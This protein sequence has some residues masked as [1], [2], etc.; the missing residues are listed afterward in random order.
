MT[1]TVLDANS[2]PQT[3]QTLPAPG[4]AAAVASSPIVLSTEDLA[5]IQYRNSPTIV[6]ATITR[7]SDTNAYT[8]GDAFAN[9][10]SA[11]TAGGF[12]LSSAVR[13]S[14]KSAW[15]EDITITSS[16]PTATALQGELL[17][18]NQAFTAINDNAA[19]T[20]SPADM[21]N[22]IV[23]IP[24]A[25]YVRGASASTVFMPIRKLVRPTGTADLRFGVCV[26]N[27]YVP[28]IGEALT[29]SATLTPED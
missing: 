19:F 4:R 27:A 7:P 24:F 1:I 15:L 3:I 18:F 9:S 12:T 11:P 25:L 21:L 16:A 14:G 5:A 17:I 8:A 20:V 23:R 26:T 22:L 2:N 6:T 28:I 10:T 29:V 13:A